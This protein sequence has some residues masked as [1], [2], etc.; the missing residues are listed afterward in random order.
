MNSRVGDTRGGDGLQSSGIYIAG[1]RREEMMEMGG[2][3]LDEEGSQPDD[4]MEIDEEE[5]E[6]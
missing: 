1:M 6:S 2:R 3:G 5:G 4:E